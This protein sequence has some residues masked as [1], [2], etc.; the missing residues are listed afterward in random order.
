MKEKP[1]FNKQ[2]SKHLN[3]LQQAQLADC[4]K[5]GRTVQINSKKKA[6][7]GWTD[8]PL[9]QVEQPKLF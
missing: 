8:T 4:I 3:Q 7:K 2:V 9:F 5:A 1:L 6:N